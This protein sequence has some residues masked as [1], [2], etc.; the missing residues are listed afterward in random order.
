[1]DEH[2]HENLID[3]IS[4]EYKDILDNSEQ[5]IYIYLD[6]DHKVCNEKFASL[7]GYESSQEWADVK[8]SFPQAFVADESQETLVNTYQEAMEQSKGSK[9]KISWKKKTGETVDSEVILVPVSH[10]GHL[11]ALHFVS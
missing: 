3:E 1:M 9:I 5:A 2:H 7:L 6:D 8:E 10:Q 11:F 4:N